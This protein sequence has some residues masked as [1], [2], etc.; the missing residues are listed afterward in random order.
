MRRDHIRVGGDDEGEGESTALAAG[1]LH[2]CLVL[3][4]PARE[5]KAAEQVLRLRSLEPSRLLRAFEDAARFVQL[6]LVLGEVRGND[7]VPQPEITGD[8]LANREQRLEQRRLAR[9]VWTDESDVLAPFQR[10]LNLGEQLF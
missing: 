8:R 2:D 7:A 3:L 10:K 9:P 6:D 1:E 4:L 5:E